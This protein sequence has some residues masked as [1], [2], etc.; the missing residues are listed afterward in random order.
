MSSV[1]GNVGESSFLS[2]P[3]WKR[4]LGTDPRKDPHAVQRER[5]RSSYLLTRTHAATLLGELS[6]SVPEFTMH[7]ITHVDA[8]WE[9]ASLVAGP[10]TALT[11]AE[12]YVLGCAFIFHDAAMG[13]AAY[14]RPF[15][16]ALGSARW[17]DLLTSVFIAETDR[18]PSTAELNAPPQAILMS[19][20]K[21]AIRETHA[22]HAAI[23]VD[24]PWRTS[25]GNDFYLLQDSSLRESY[26][27]LIGELASSH[28]W[29]IND[30]AGPFRN[31]KGSLPWQP[32]EWIVDPLKIACILRLAD[33]TQLDSRRAP[34]FLFALRR[35]EGTSW[36]H[37]RFQ[38]HMGR[39]QLIGDRI[40]YSAFRPFD[41]E[42]ASA[43]W[44]ALDY[45]R[46]VDS[47]LKGR[48]A[49]V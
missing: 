20:V 22:A 38:E 33:A 42:D 14:E 25:S 36:D 48:R 29:N 5:L 35:P 13:L 27:P 40:I 1:G 34:T 11:P 41:Q 12:A 7:D 9:T 18:W 23:L 45:L 37:W 2:S 15:T 19:C 43:W 26:G 21:Q 49:T 3:L 10:E 4:T 44:L 32:P 30:L 16:D 6:L 8:L 47:E 24:Q 31:T 17:R 28:W 39:P 46:H